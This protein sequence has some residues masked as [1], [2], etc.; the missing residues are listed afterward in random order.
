MAREPLPEP[1]RK[2]SS[3]LGAYTDSLKRI[4]ASSEVIPTE[5]FQQLAGTFTR[6]LNLI[7]KAYPEM[8]DAE[9]DAARPHIL[10]WRQLQG[11][12]VFLLRFPDILQVPH[13]AEITQALDFIV[14]QEN[15]LTEIYVPLA[16]QE[17]NLFAGQFRQHLEECL[18][19]RAQHPP[20]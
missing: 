15:I 11:Y 8:V 18:G 2:F 14:H 5:T 1:I 20:E 12:L 10:Y 9:K 13:H 3:E 16:R 17:K 4:L 6:L 7:L 19:K